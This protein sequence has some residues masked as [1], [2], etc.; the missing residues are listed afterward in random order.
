LFYGW[1]LVH[2][3]GQES[4]LTGSLDSISKFALMGGAGSGGAARQ[5]LSALRQETAQ[6]SGVLVV[7]MVVLIN[8]E[9]ANFSALTVL[10]PVISIKCQVQFLLT[11]EY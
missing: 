5:N 1:I 11:L 3:I 8:A 2:N 4:Y 10:V 6:L 9:L 7:Y